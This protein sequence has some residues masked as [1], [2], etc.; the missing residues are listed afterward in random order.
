MPAPANRPRASAS[1]STVTGGP[2]DGRLARFPR[3]GWSPDETIL[4][5]ASVRPSTS[6]ARQSTRSTP[7]K[8][9]PPATRNIKRPDGDIQERPRCRAKSVATVSERLTGTVAQ[10]RNHLSSFIDAA[11]SRSRIL[12]SFVPVNGFADC[13]GRED[14]VPFITP[15]LA[16][17]TCCSYDHPRPSFDNSHA[18][19]MFSA[20]RTF[21]A[22]NYAFRFQCLHSVHGPSDLGPR[23]T[24]TST[25]R[26]LGPGKVT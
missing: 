20:E 16:P 9:E 24:P 26:E 19:N 23:C 17:P 2:R 3:R 8:R 10:Q 18:E 1:R 7:S 22:V 25:S 5:C 14:A 12:P 13:I 6:S 11:P 15:P 4:Y 21:Y